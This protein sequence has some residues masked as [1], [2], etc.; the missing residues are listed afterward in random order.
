MKKN[1][2]SKPV[3]A[4]GTSKNHEGKCNRF[5]FEIAV[6]ETRINPILYHLYASSRMLHRSVQDKNAEALGAIA[7]NTPIAE[8]MLRRVQDMK[9][10]ALGSYN[11]MHGN[12]AVK[13][14]KDDLVIQIKIIVKE[15]PWQADGR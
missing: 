5:W 12:N 1:N 7:I 15:E 2:R 4:F 3:P 10:R 8:M 13:V 11:S 9:A 14:E 6:G